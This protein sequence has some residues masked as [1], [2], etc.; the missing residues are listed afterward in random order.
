MHDGSGSAPADHGCTGSAG[1][2]SG[3]VSAGAA[4]SCTTRAHS[5]GKAPYVPRPSQPRRFCRRCGV[6]GGCCWR[7]LLRAVARLLLTAPAASTLLLLCPFS[8]FNTLRL[9]LRRR[10]RRRPR[11]QHTSFPSR[12]HAYVR[13]DRSFLSITDPSWLRKI[14]ACACCLLLPLLELLLM[15]C[16]YLFFVAAAGGVAVAVADVVL[17]GSSHVSP[18]CMLHFCSR[19]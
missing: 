2:A 8:M 13:I 7:L 1:S 10:L 9:R 18:V 5:G 16:T 11:V 4:A 12:A 6:A 14:C 3:H 15:L 17:I 19:E